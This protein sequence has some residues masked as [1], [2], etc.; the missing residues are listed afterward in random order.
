MKFETN[1]L[2][3]CSNEGVLA[4]IRRVAALTPGVRLTRH[5]FNLHAR[6]KISAVE[7]RFGSWA[8]A[9]RKAGLFDA[10]PIYTEDAILS[11]IR[12]VSALSQDERFTIAEYSKH[13][14]YSSSKIKRRFG[15]WREALDRAGLGDRYVGPPV[16]ERMKA[17]RGRAMSDDDILEGIRNVAAQLGNA[18]LSGATIE[19]NSEITL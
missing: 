9:T 16:T 10:L 14:Q 1:W 18:P 17:Q 12:R 3:D 15:G 11:D 7:R 13:G 8:E 6:I 5:V 4:E 19:A 2:E